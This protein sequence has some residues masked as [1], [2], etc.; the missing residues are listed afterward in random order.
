MTTT[1][2]R[3]HHPSLARST[4]PSPLP[5]PMST[6]LPPTLC[7]RDASKG[8]MGLFLTCSDGGLQAW[9]QGA[10][11]LHTELSNPGKHIITVPLLCMATALKVPTAFPS[12]PHNREGAADKAQ[13]NERICLGLYH[14]RETQN[15]YLLGWDPF[16]SPCLGNSESGLALTPELTPSQPPQPSHTALQIQHRP[17]SSTSCAPGSKGGHI[18]AFHLCLV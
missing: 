15:P 4:F 16:S 3:P 7:W 11:S 10:Q 18:T 2:P 13:R 6:L 17:P 8:Q 5:H 1:Q 12:T 9:C 14:W